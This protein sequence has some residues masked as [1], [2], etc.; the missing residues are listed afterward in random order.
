M[1]KNRTKTQLKEDARLKVQSDLVLKA[2]LAEHFKISTATIER[3]IKK[4]NPYLCF[5][6]P[7]AIIASKLGKQ[8]FELIEINEPKK[9][10]A[11]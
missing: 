3:W 8:E 5:A 2:M 10:E 6:E 4:N 1:Q 7:L 9:E 11:A